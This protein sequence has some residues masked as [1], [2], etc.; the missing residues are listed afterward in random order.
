MKTW[1]HVTGKQNFAQVLTDGSKKYITREAHT[2]HIN[3]NS[4]IDDALRVRRNTHVPP[5]VL[6]CDVTE[7]QSATDVFHIVRNLKLLLP[8]LSLLLKKNTK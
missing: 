4:S 6:C 5:L 1:C 2:Y 8:L 7:M 3:I